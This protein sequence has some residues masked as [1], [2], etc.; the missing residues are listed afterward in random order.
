MQLRDNIA[1]I[2]KND[3][4]TKQILEAKY[5]GLR[6]IIDG[7]YEE[8][9][10]LYIFDNDACTYDYLQD[11][12]GLCKEFALEDFEVPIEIWYEYTGNPQPEWNYYHYLK[13]RGLL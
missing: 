8:G 5:N 7:E 10:Y 4:M 2:Q 13:N 1:I 6:F 11:S 3:F 9:A 12:I